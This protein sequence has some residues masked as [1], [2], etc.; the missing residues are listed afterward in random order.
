MPWPRLPFAVKTCLVFIAALCL[1]FLWPKHP[2][3]N[4]VA[5]PSAR[6]QIPKPISAPVTQQEEQSSA[7]LA[8]LSNFTFAT[9]WGSE[10]YPA[11]KA[12]S[13]WAAD[14]KNAS[15]AEQSALLPRGIEL[16]RER[17]AAFQHLIRTH[18]KLALA[19][20]VPALVRDELPQAV[21]ELLE[22]R[23]SGKGDLI[24]LGRA[25]PRDVAAATRRALIN[26]R[27][28][29]A[30]VYGDRT[31]QH[32][33]WNISL[34]GVAIDNEIALS[35]SPLRVFEPGETVPADKPLAADSCVVSQQ[36]AAPASDGPR[37]HAV[38]AESGSHVYWMCHGKHVQAAAGGVNEQEFQLPFQ[39]YATTGARTALIILVDFSDRQ[40]AISDNATIASAFTNVQAFLRTNSYGDFE[41]T[42]HTVTPVLRMPRNSSGYTDITVSS[43]DSI[44]LNDARNA[45][46]NAGFN[47]DNFDF[48]M[49]AFPE[50][51]FR[52]NGQGY[53][54]T[55]GIWIQG[56]FAPGV[57]SHEVGHNLGLWHANSWNSFESSISPGGT[58]E[59]YGNI[60]DVMG[61]PTIGFP[62]THY[63]GN[64]KRL[65]GWLA[66][67][68][69]NTINSSGTY[70][71]YAHDQNSRGAGRHYA[72]K[73]PGG[74][75]AG[76]EIQDYWIDFRQALTNIYPSTDN[77]VVVQWGND[78]GTQSASRILDMAFSTPEKTDA[79]LQA[80]QTFGDADLGLTVKPLDKVGVGADA[81][82][83]VEVTLQAPPTVPLPEAVDAPDF[84]WA[85]SGAPWTGKRNVSHDG[86]DAAVSAPVRDNTE[87]YI[88]TTVEG[89]GA[90]FFWWKVSSE[91]EFDHLKLVIDGQEKA[92]IS[93]Q[94]DWEKRGYEL[95]AGTHTIRWVYKKDS[96]SL[97]G[98]DR[99]WLDEVTFVTG[100]FAPYINAQPAST[101][102]GVGE[103]AEVHVDAIGSAPLAYQWYKLNEAGEPVAVPGAMSATLTIPGVQYDDE[104]VYHCVVTNNVA[105][106]TSANAVLT[107][108]RFVSLA[109]AVDNSIAEWTTSGAVEWRGQQ[110]VTHDNSD[111]AQ[112]GI[113]VHGKESSLN[114]TIQGPGTLTFW[115]KVSSEPDYD[116]LTLYMDGEFVEQHSGEFDWAQKTLS[117]PNGVHK[118]RWT[119]SKDANFS[120]GA[121]SAWVDQ[122]VFAPWTNAAPQ[123]VTQPAGQAVSIGGAALFTAEY[124]ATEPAV[125]VWLKNGEPLLPAPNLIGLNTDTLCVTN[126]QEGDAGSYSLMIS[127]AFG[128]TNS[129]P[130]VLSVVPFSLADALDQP[131]R[132]FITGGHA[133][134][135]AQTSITHDAVDAA[136]SGAIGDDQFTWIETRVKGPATVSFWWKASSEAD[137]DFMLFELDATPMQRISG[138]ADWRRETVTLTAGTHALRW[139]YRKDK[140]TPSG[141]DAGWLDQIEITPGPFEP[142]FINVTHDANGIAATI[143]GLPQAG[144]VILECSTNLLTWRPFA[145]N[146]ISGATVNL[147]RA[148]TNSAEFIRVRLE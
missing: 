52:W 28:Y 96:G 75:V 120:E 39:A 1:L 10:K 7:A 60:F 84:P 58:H 117:I 27:E 41:L 100:E 107:V 17:R 102:V 66:P 141:D 48:D 3:Q 113:L 142:E 67:E 9:R 33:R 72:L 16:A 55:K 128:F 69:V 130:A 59:E 44:L 65:I 29:E 40:G 73:I 90:L 61:R 101:T 78:S 133:P 132:A 19:Q 111:A 62:D 94:I 87:T 143:Q 106:V 118:L 129:N 122:V 47:P 93:G 8:D 81:F 50:V 121:D 56:A 83:D 134:W 4:I 109:D 148:T 5:A 91:P 135:T 105:T 137:Y 114:A 124:M 34:H 11:L 89:P 42:S 32:T 138:A 115:W 24:A 6:N 18:P 80:G 103:T 45:A 22:Q 131:T 144:N 123:F 74:I 54:G 70:R 37:P 57:V 147:R 15:A 104:G 46:R 43:G 85:T 63:S 21:V 126:V 97:R 146:A 99:G 13:K 119:Y 92:S 127:N 125:F 53:V 25:G 31:S 2:N 14:F 49:V 108:V 79:P 26:S 98:A 68:H 30:F 110:A 95:G 51:G 20:T 116:L 23:V 145:T 38:A 82:M 76:D 71:L 136:R 64:F 86:T 36:P 112:S 88:E 12:F 140:N 35:D 77:A 139:K